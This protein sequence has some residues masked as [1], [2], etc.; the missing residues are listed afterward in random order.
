LQ[1]HPDEAIQ[2]L[3]GSM[4]DLLR[5]CVLLAD[6]ILRPDDSSFLEDYASIMNNAIDAIDCVGVFRED[7]NKISLHHQRAGDLAWNVFNMFSGGITTNLQVIDFRGTDHSFPLCSRPGIR[8]E[9]SR[10]RDGTAHILGSLEQKRASGQAESSKA[11]TSEPTVSFVGHRETLEGFVYT[12][13]FERQYADWAWSAAG[14]TMPMYDRP[15]EQIFTEYAVKCIRDDGNLDIL[16]DVEDRSLRRVRTI[17]GLPSWVPDFSFPLALTPMAMWKTNKNEGLYSAS[18]SSKADPKWSGQ[19]GGAEIALAGCQIDEISSLASKE[20]AE[21][22]LGRRLFVTKRGYI[23]AGPLSA[24]VGD[25]VYVL[26]AGHV[27]L[28]LRARSPGR[29]G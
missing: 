17:P 22:M 25:A 20:S 18:G 8:D 2:K 19:A 21:V 12:V 27:P 9:V 28:L 6:V 3:Y 11:Q 24:R 15:V 23:G 10:F 5:G 1:D 29:A 14:W 26:A 4:R 13:E 7:S 16:S